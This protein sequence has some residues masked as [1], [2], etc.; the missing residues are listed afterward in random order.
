MKI[1]SMV[2]VVCANVLLLTGCSTQVSPTVGHDVRQAT[3]VV[4]L[5]TRE[6]LVVMH[7]TGPNVLYTVKTLDGKMML[8]EVSTQELQ[9]SLPQLYEQISTLI[10][11][12][13]WA[14]M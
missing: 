12:Y 6:H 7:T 1:I 14:G 3:P 11:G 8:R 5:K 13:L 10:A 9:A 4:Q 2:L